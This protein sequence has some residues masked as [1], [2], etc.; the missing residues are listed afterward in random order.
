M[1][2]SRKVPKDKR[3]MTVFRHLN[4]RIAKKNLAYPLL[5]DIKAFRKFKKILWDLT[6]FW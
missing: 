5:K 3:V 1:L 2:I 6:I 4:V